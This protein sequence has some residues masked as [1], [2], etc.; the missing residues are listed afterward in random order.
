MA[1]RAGD[2]ILDLKPDCENKFENMLTDIRK[3]AI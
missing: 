2:R 3:S 1:D